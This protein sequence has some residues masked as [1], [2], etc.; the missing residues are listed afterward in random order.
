M[1][2]VAGEAVRNVDR[3]A[4]QAAQLLPERN[5]RLRLVQPARRRGDLGMDERERGA[6]ELA[7]KPEGVAGTRAGAR[8]RLPGRNVAERSDIDGA[9]RAACGVAADQLDA[10]GLGKGKQ[11]RGKAFQPVFIDSRYRDG[12]GE[13]ARRGAACGKVREVHRKALVAERAR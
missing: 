3:G 7:R 12:E 5:A 13:P 1:A 4:R 10:V 9:D 11:A 8:E 6:A 2:E